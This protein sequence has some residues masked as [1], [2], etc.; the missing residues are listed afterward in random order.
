MKKLY[1]EFKELTEFDDQA[2][3]AAKYRSPIPFQNRCGDRAKIVVRLILHEAQTKLLVF[4]GCLHSDVYADPSVFSA[5][6]DMIDRGVKLKVLLEEPLSAKTDRSEALEFVL[7]QQGSGQVEVRQASSAYQPQYKQQACHMMIADGS[8]LRIETG[9]EEFVAT[10]C[11][12]DP[13]MARV[14]EEN[15]LTE[16]WAKGT[17]L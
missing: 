7:A 6:K 4:A 15:F 10:V 12:N 5:L 9:K 17:C 13:K 16:G 8:M 11:F 14:L 1:P 2:C 3:Q